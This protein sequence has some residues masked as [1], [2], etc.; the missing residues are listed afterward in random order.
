MQ[1]IPQENPIG[2]L[3]IRRRSIHGPLSCDGSMER[4]QRLLC[5]RGWR[6]IRRWPPRMQTGRICAQHVFT[7]R[8]PALTRCDDPWRYGWEKEKCNLHLHYSALPHTKPLLKE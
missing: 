6:M 5:F 1:A 8:V 3:S 7:V 4:Q 2:S